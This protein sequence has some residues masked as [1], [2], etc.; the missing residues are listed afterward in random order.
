MMRLSSF[1][2]YLSRRLGL[3]VWLIVKV[4]LCRKAH[5]AFDTLSASYDLT[6][7]VIPLCLND[8]RVGV[9]ACFTVHLSPYATQ[10]FNKA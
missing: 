8:V 2:K 9:V 6:T 10:G 1:L 4:L 5:T 7:S 3:I